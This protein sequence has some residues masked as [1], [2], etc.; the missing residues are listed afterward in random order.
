MPATHRRGDG[1]PGGRTR[2][3]GAAPG[4]PGAQARPRRQPLTRASGSFVACPDGSATT[5]SVMAD[6]ARKLENRQ[7]VVDEQGRRT[8]VVLP[9]D[10]YEELLEAAEQRD[11]IRHLEAAQGPSGALPNDTLTAAEAIARTVAP[12]AAPVQGDSSKGEMEAAE[13]PGFWAKAA[14]IFSIPAKII[15]SMP[16]FL[17]PAIVN[18]FSTDS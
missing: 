6:A 10:E 13:K 9:I 5:G 11:D 2:R 1:A 18:A 16:R 7:Y 12:A 4:A 17:Y 15:K 14:D 3:A 8:A